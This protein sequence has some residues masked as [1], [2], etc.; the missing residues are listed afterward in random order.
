MGLD[1]ERL[2]HKTRTA[3]DVQERLG[4][5]ALK[6]GHIT[7]H[8]QFLLQAFVLFSSCFGIDHY[9]SLRPMTD[10]A[11]VVTKNEVCRLRVLRRSQSLTSPVKAPVLI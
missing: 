1:E 10:S 3:F 6:L 11:R 2:S 4:S 5:E 9:P 8:S 7:I